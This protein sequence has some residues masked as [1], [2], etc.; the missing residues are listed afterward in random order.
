[1]QWRTVGKNIQTAGLILVLGWWLFV[2]YRLNLAFTT[3]GYQLPWYEALYLLF[4]AVG[5]LLAFVLFGIDK[6]RA[7]RDQP[8]ISERTLLLTAL[9]GGWPGSVIGA[10]VFRHKTVKVSFRTLHNLIVTAHLALIGYIIYE[11][12]NR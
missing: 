8:R 2:A 9:L 1:M 12:W 4:T 10:V 3:T 7:V 5:S 6:R 11:R